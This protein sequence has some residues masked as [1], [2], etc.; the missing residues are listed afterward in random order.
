[1]S[2]ENSTIDC[3]SHANYGYMEIIKKRVLNQDII[4]EDMFP[5]PFPYINKTVQ[6]N[7]DDNNST[8]S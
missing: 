8:T 6:P 3:G 5:N 7:N 1:M 4:T 2:C